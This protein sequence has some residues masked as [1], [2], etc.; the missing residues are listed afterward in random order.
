M[1]RSLRMSPVRWHWGHLSVIMSST[2]R[3]RRARRAK[4]PSCEQIRHLPHD[5]ASPSRVKAS[6]PVPSR[7]DRRLSSR[8]VFRQAKPSTRTV[9]IGLTWLRTTKGPY[10]QTLCKATSS[11]AYHGSAVSEIGSALF[12]VIAIVVLCA[13]V[14]SLP[15]RS[16]EE[17]RQRTAGV[18]TPHW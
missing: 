11:A 13:L 8:N 7:T 10:V 3:K 17:R 1:T 9:T 18:R 4:R 6:N 15:A 16:R 2:S 5:T 14:W 12:Q